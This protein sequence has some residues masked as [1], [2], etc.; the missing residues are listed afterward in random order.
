MTYPTN[1]EKIIVIFTD[2]AEV[3]F[4][5]LVNKYNLK[6]SPEEELEHAKKGKSTR[7]IMI[8][9]GIRAF[10]GKEISPEDFIIAISKLLNIDQQQS[11]Q[12]V[13]D[14]KRDIVP[15]LESFPEENLKD[16]AFAENMAR[17]IFGEDIITQRGVKDI[18]IKS[19][20]ENA[21]KL[22]KE[23]EERL[24]QGTVSQELQQKWQSDKYREPL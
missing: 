20:E 14:I 6:E 16:P 22:K 5:V 10:A 24:R 11:Q 18:R 1:Q 23:R 4:N 9:K 3:A 17:K 15:L 2:K 13:E 21:E 12:I 19:V 8:R 7:L